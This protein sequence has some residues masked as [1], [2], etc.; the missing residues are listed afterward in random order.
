[1]PWRM[2]QASVS[3]I[4]RSSRPVPRFTAVARLAVAA[5]L[6]AA[7]A[8]TAARAQNIVPNP[9]FE[10]Q[11]SPWTQFLSAAPDPSGSGAAS[12]WVAAPDINKSASSGSALIDID[13]T[14]P[15]TDASSG[16]AQ[17]FDLAGA[18]SVD[19]VNY[20]VSFLVPSTT[21]AD[22]SL[23]ATVEVRL[24]ANTGCS[25]FLSGGSQ[26]QTLTPGTAS[27]STWYKL[28]DTGFVPPGAPVMVASA[29]VRGYLR[30]TGPTPTQSDY[31]AN[32]DHFFLIIN[33]TTPVRLLNFDVE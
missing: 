23:S 27:D 5:V 7:G 11:L 1:M 21:T 8:G 25:G 33:S 18:T 19:F 16:I 22:A 12:S 31:K 3:A 24:Y 15:A 17:C 9:D 30:Q 28:N 26:G 14:T 4:A 32:F 2:K 20:G 6:V 10:S 29:E 13:T